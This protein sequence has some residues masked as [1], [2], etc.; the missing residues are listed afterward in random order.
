ML[1]ISTKSRNTIQRIAHQV[2]PNRY[3]DTLEKSYSH[4]EY[5]RR[6]D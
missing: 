1:E 5:I 3:R 4:P 2:D 6:G